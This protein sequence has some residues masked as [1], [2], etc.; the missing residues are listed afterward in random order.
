MKYFSLYWSAELC[1]N[2]ASSTYNPFSVYI[3]LGKFAN[4]EV[5]F[6][7]S[8]LNLKGLQN[9]NGS[10]EDCCKPKWPFSWLIVQK[11]LMTNFTEIT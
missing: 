10:S 1:S 11:M 8:A 2:E 9:S 7:R 5:D 4:T 3:S 6:V